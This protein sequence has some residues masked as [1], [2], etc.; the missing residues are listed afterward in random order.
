V[1]SRLHE[2]VEAKLLRVPRSQ[3]KRHGGDTWRR[4]ALL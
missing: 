3:C 1:F 2:F 4:G